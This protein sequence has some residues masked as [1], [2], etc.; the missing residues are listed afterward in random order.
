MAVFG[1]GILLLLSHLGG[2][3]REGSASGWSLMIGI[4][5]LL[6]GL[7][8]T[9]LFSILIR[10][11]RIERQVRPSAGDAHTDA[12]GLYSERTQANDP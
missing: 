10:L 7:I 4:G 5:F 6:I 12:E 1:C 9:L 2:Q 3:I 8:S 11:D